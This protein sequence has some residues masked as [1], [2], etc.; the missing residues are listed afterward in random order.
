MGKLDTHI[1]T[2]E[3]KELNA[4]FK[5]IQDSRPKKS[6]IVDG[7][8]LIG[9]RVSLNKMGYEITEFI[10]NTLITWENF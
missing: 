1:R 7:H 10:S 6:V 3:I 2:K 8:I 4:I 9:T 5:L